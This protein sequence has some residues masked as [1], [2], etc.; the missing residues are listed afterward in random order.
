MVVPTMVMSVVRYRRCKENVGRT[1]CRRIVARAAGARNAEM[2]YTALERAG[3]VR[4]MRS[5]NL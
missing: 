2:M 4:K 1:V 3:R 5:M